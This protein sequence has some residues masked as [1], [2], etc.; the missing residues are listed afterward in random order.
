MK[1]NYIKQEL[2]E[3][4]K[5]LN[6]RYKVVRS[7]SMGYALFINSDNLYWTQISKWYKYYGNLKR[8][9]VNYKLMILLNEH[10]LYQIIN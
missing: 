6:F 3:V 10:W 1:E 7:K 2:T 8:C 9:S 5:I 4:E